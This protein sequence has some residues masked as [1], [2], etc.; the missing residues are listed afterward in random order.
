MITMPTPVHPD[1][2]QTDAITG[3]RPR[4]FAE[5]DHLVGQ[6]DQQAADVGALLRALNGRGIHLVLV[7]VAVPFVTPLPLPGVSI[8]FGFVVAL[9][10]VGLATDRDPWFPQRLLRHEVSPRTLAR[11][12]R[13]SRSLGAALEWFTRPRLRFA[14]S[15]ATRRL[16]GAIIAVC[17]ALPM[18]PLP[19][20]FCNSLP[21]ATVLLLAV[22]ELGRDGLLFII[23]C[24]A[25]VLTVVFF[26]FVGAGAWEAFAALRGLFLGP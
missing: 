21:A 26:A 23:G 10:G 13:A 12:F 1:L 7:L 24:V 5:F 25:F 8:P 9:L 6:F 3:A 2:R 22:A 14:R 18:L 15:R 4:V 11:I 17:G 20:P 19:I 16:G